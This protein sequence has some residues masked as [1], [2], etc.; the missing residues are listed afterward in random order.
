[1]AAAAML[2]TPK[3]CKQVQ[4]LKHK[5]HA[6][7]TRIRHNLSRYDGHMKAISET[8]YRKLFMLLQ[9]SAE[10]FPFYDDFQ[11]RSLAPRRQAV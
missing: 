5:K 10:W 1:M 7:L 2:S 8:H 4:L 11:D 6:Q 3:T 9:R